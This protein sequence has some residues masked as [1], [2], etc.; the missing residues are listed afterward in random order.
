MRKVL[1][2]SGEYLFILALCWPGCVKAQD[3]R[4][5][6]DVKPDHWAY[7]AATDLHNRGI[8]SGYPEGHF[9]GRRT[10]TRYEFAVA[11][12]RALDALPGDRKSKIGEPPQTEQNGEPGSTASAGLTGIARTEVDDLR[13]LTVM[14]KD[15]LTALGANTEDVLAK[16]NKLSTAA[17]ASARRPD[18][19]VPTIG[20]SVPGR[21]FDR[22]LY[23]LGNYGGGAPDSNSNLFGSLRSIYVQDG[24]G[25]RAKFGSATATLF[26][27]SLGSGIGSADSGFPGAGLNSQRLGPSMQTALP[28]GQQFYSGARALNYGNAPNPGYLNLGGPAPGRIFGLQGDLPLSK[29]GTIGLT[30]LDFSADRGG[31]NGSG[32][33]LLGAPIGDVTVYGANLRLNSIGRFALFG[34]ASKSVTQRRFTDD[35]GNSDDNNA[36]LLNLNYNGGPVTG[37]AGYQYYDPRFTAPGYLNKLGS[38]YNPTNLQG[39]FARVGGRVDRLSAD[40]GVDF[41]TAARNRPGFGGFT[42]GSSVF[43]GQAGLGYHFSK[44]FELTANYEGV[45]YDMS[46]AISASGMRAKPVEQYITLG[47]GLNLSGSTVLRLAYQIINVQDAG[48]GFG[49]APAF[50]GNSPGGTA[51]TSVVTTQFA[52]HF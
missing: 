22:A 38:S 48:N 50:G 17:G 46:G 41:L 33:G 11:L 34:E 9:N 6:E 29:N 37:T 24:F 49:L 45:L 5:F 35:G 40:L 1:P 31:F 52:V 10:L 26:G 36:Y 42:Q 39:P 15:E 20:N 23:A 2:L 44:Q 51:N 19:I 8:I 21:R 18:R 13:R 25:I 3:A 16:L 30:Y 14:F 4:P 43:R 47:A 7:Q 12:K 28:S 32:S 27:G